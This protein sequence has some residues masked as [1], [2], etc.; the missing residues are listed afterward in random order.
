[1]LSVFMLS[2]VYLGVVTPA[3]LLKTF[4]V[5]KLS[6][7]KVRSIIMRSPQDVSIFTTIADVTTNVFSLNFV[8]NCSSSPSSSL[9][10]Q[11]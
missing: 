8:E 3:L 9:S 7:S 5:K 6:S 10:T 2:I 11:I 1:M 4:Q